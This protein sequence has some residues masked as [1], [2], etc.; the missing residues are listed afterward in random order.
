MSTFDSKGN[1]NKMGNISLYKVV[2]VFRNESK[3]FRQK[4]LVYQCTKLE[5]K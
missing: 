2:P 1:K 5:C 4:H 3:I